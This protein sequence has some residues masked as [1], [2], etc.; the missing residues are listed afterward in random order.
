MDGLRVVTPA[1]AVAQVATGFGLRAGV[2]AG[3]QSPGETL[4]RMVAQ[5]LGYEVDTQFRVVDESGRSIAYAD[6][7]SDV[8]R[9]DRV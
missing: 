4:L 8:T 3:G 9:S 7:R 1:V 2:V 6:L 5:D